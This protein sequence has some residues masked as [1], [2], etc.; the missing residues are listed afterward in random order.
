MGSKVFG[1]KN[2]GITYKRAM[3]YIFH[4][5]I[6]TFM[7]IYI[8]YIVVKCFDNHSKNEK[9]WFKNESSQVCFLHAGRGLSRICGPQKGD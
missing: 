6:E 4:D 2:A 9:L 8:D 5:F 3:N 7:H 1:L